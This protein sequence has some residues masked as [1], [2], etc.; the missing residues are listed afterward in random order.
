V[1]ILFTPSYSSFIRSVLAGLAMTQAGPY[2]NMGRAPVTSM[3]KA[4]RTT[5]SGKNAGT[6]SHLISSIPNESS[7]VPGIMLGY[8]TDCN[9][10][11]PFLTPTYKYRKVTLVPFLCDLELQAAA[12]SRV[13]GVSNLMV[14]YK[15]NKGFS[16]QTMKEANSSESW[17]AVHGPFTN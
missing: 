15:E 8:I 1:L 16:F 2:C 4:T 3:H 7:P 5:A 9:I 6:T 11:E 12:W 17:S 14:S 10:V 13:F